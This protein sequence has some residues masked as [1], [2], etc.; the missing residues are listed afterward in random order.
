MSGTLVTEISV[1]NVK[2]KSWSPIMPKQREQCL[3]S[4]D[5]TYKILNPTAQRRWILNLPPKHLSD[6][7][8]WMI[9]SLI[10]NKIDV[11]SWWKKKIL[12]K[13]VVSSSVNTPVY[14]ENFTF[15][16]FLPEVLFRGF[17]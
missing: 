7:F 4:V 6:I 14:F 13:S 1:S 10:E 11:L 9:L 12:E 15:N 2:T 3:F 16:K 5:R 17:P 8:V